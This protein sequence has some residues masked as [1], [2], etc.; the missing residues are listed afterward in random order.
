MS[1]YQ[2]FDQ[3]T[4][5]GCP[6]GCDG[7]MN[8]YFMSEIIV[9]MR[10]EL[11]FPFTIPSGGAYRCEDYDDKKGAH[12]GHALDILCS[13]RQRSR[14]IAWL[15]HRNFRIDRGELLGRKVTRIGINNGS[16]HID[17]LQEGE[18]GKSA[19]VVWDYYG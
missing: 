16:I 1:N 6:C 5:L 9:P 14:I 12:Q 4:E 10:K 15:E 19:N 18:M 11:D 2:Y 3:D 17:D 8:N 7:R 13:S